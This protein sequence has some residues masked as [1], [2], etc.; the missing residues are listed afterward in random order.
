MTLLAQQQ[1]FMHQVQT[2]DPAQPDWAEVSGHMEIYINAYS[3]RMRQA[4]ADNFPVLHSALGD[5]GFDAL[6]SAYCA[7]H[8]STH[9]SIRWLGDGLVDFMQTHPDTV[10][11][12][13]LLDIAR[14]DWAMRAAFDAADAECLQLQDLATLE[15][16]DW[17]TLS[18]RAVPSLRV[19]HLEWG[20]E[21]LWHTLH[22]D[23]NAQTSEPLQAAHGMRVWRQH[24]ECRW[25]SVDATETIALQWLQPGVS[26]GDL[27]E[28]LHQAG[29]ANPAQKAAELL[30][31][32]VTDGL[33]AQP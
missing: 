25:R 2:G 20:V 27:C 14:M 12:P 21:A 6:A 4:L 10:P 16:S 28:G 33:L 18:L 23:A 31:T 8:P 13:A 3:A 5:D 19:L 32:W 7:A 9:R 24:L 1:G 17:P 26:F 30:Q 29:V 11:H 22:A 15:P